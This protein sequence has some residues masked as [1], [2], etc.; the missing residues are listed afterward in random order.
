LVAWSDIP[1]WTLASARSIMR[2]VELKDPETASH[3]VRVGRGS[4]LLAQAAG[5]DQYMQ[6]LCE[7][8]GL[9]HDI[10]KIGVPDEILFKPAKL[11]EEE[12]NRM[13]EHPELSVE[14]LKPLAEV[15]PFVRDLLPGV[16]H[17]HE[18]FDGRGY[19]VGKMGDA[20]PLEARIILI[21][22]TFDAMTATR[23]YRKGLPPEA[24]YAELELHAGRQ[25]DPRLVKVFLEAQPRWT[26]E[27]KKVAHEFAGTV[28]KQVA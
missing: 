14:A 9:F 27:E 26:R 8:A 18:R 4:R 21:A 10:G 12:Y 17:H 25:F 20:I 22:D 19:P 13:K 15:S 28:Y 16:R 5:L 11:T 1:D 2:T 7:F 6:K 3:C 23:A 24:A